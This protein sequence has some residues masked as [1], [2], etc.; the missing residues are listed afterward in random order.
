MRRRQWVTTGSLPRLISFLMGFKTS[1]HYAISIQP[2]RVK[3]FNASLNFKHISHFIHI[4]HI[5]VLWWYIACRSWWSYRDYWA[6]KVLWLVTFGHFE[7]SVTIFHRS[8][9]V[10]LQIWHLICFL[11]MYCMHWLVVTYRAFTSLW[12]VMG[13]PKVKC[14]DFNVR[15]RLFTDLVFLS[16]Y[17]SCHDSMRYIAYVVVTLSESSILRYVNC[18]YY[19][20]T[21]IYRS[22]N[23][24]HRF[25][26]PL[27]I[28]KIII[29]T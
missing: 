28:F 24:S 1:Y 11:I 10:F 14:F 15:I 12:L 17:W 26:Q 8:N 6:C 19:R 18:G 21:L 20:V 3:A 13:S 16:Y 7:S 27:V 2:F 4:S 5:Y 23:L 25:Q 22:V 9:T 29:R